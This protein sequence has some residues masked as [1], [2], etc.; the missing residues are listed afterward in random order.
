[1]ETTN[2]PSLSQNTFKANS[3][4][5]LLVF[6]GFSLFY[7]L[8]FSPV[9][10]SSRLL[11]PGDGIAYYLPAFYGAKTLWTNLIFGGYPIAADPQN[12]TWYPPAFLLGL[13]PHS[14]NAF[15]VLAYV[16]AGSFAYCYVYIV[17]KSKLAATVTGLTYSMSGFMVAHL[18]HVTMIH[19]AAWISLILCSLEKLRHKF[20][21]WWFAIGILAVACCFLG[22]HPQ[23]SVYGIGL[24]FFYAL[25]L[26]WSAP[27]GRGK[28]YRWAFGVIIIGVFLCA[29]Q[30]F[31]TI[32]LSQLS[33]R[34][35][36]PLEAFLQYSLPIWQSLQL[37]FPYFFGG[38]IPP[39]NN[40]PYWGEWSLTEITGY[41]GLLPIIL[42]LTGFIFYPSRSVVRFWFWFGL[43]TLLAAFG[44]ELLIGK[45]L[46]YVPI[47]NNFRAQG[48]HF[49][50]VALAISVLSGFGISSI[51]R[52]LVSQRSVFKIISISCVA[53]LISLISMGISYKSFI[54]KSSKFGIIDLKIF[55]WENPAVAIPILIFGI[56]LIT[57]TLWYRY[58]N[59]QWSALLLVTVI[60]VDLSSFGW[61][62][63]WQINSPNVNR[64]NPSEIVLKYRTLLQISNGRFL[65]PSGSISMESNGLFPNLTR[66]WDFPNAA[67]YSP[68]TLTRMSQLMQMDA[69]GALYFLP[70]KES[71]RQLDLMSVRYLFSPGSDMSQQDGLIWTDTDLDFLLGASDCTSS[72]TKSSITLDLPDIP[73]KTMAIGFITQLGCSVEVPDQAEVAQIQVVDAQGNV[74]THSLLAGRDTAEHAYDCPDVKPHMQ[75]Q[76]AQVF[77][78]V[79]TSR[80]GGGAC[81]A[82]EYV[83]MVR[84]NRSQQIS[85]LKL[86]W[87]NLPAAMNIKHISLINE[88]QG[89]SLPLTS[90]GLSKKWRKVEQISSGII[91]ENQQVMP[92]AWLVPE[93][94]VLKPE[95]VLTAVHTSELPDGRTYDPKTM[96]LVEDGTAQ[97][98]SSALQSTDTVKVVSLEETRVELQTQ[99]SA[100]AFLVLSDV[101]YPG[102]QATID[103]KRT[104]IFQTNYIQRGIKL[105]AGEH[106]VRFEFH[107][108][109]FKLGVGI[110]MAS[111]FGGGYWLFRAKR[112]EY[113]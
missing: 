17:T 108:L 6:L 11:A 110:T 69:S 78:S 55:P 44:G 4:H 76:R 39:Y 75:H 15:I 10:F 99:A 101:F 48:R 102:W 30:L 86:N 38:F 42:S 24:G 13:I 111:F 77:R 98:Q 46:Y 28:Y 2:N 27:I 68:L 14:W 57:L 5:S 31:P 58:S 54:D 96:A 103:G 21:P 112:N 113:I 72:K 52:Q 94:I 64:L 32:E 90:L 45:V 97:F 51:Q 41:V 65:N 73:Y 84:L 63:E 23:I 85:N 80:P 87:A 19:A 89:T 36:M 79:P 47:Y 71:D 1:M 20:E 61:F 43:I 93:T 91:Y 74:E 3:Y 67:G 18:G 7:T 50:E 66:L 35:E 83:A 16:L 95:E 100:P 22:G 104:P 25:F 12:M 53:M 29:I 33:L 60:V 37:F 88:S 8:F 34:A 107:P 9:L 62:Y 56:S 26:G 70:T 106:M 109:S 81:Q 59:M 49:V 92:R 82:H 105:P 40:Y